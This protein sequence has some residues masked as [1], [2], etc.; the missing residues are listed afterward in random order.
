MAELWGQRLLQSRSLFLAGSDVLCQPVETIARL[1][2]CD[3]AGVSDRSRSHTVRVNRRPET[4]TTPRLDG[5]HAF[6]DDFARPR[7]DG[8]GWRELAA[9]GLSRVSLGVESGSQEVRIDLPQKLGR[10][11]LAID[12]DGMQGGGSS[13]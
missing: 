2:G 10:R 13:A 9:R 8:A 12:G 3:R 1:P 4:K 6:L 7:P 5:V 11:W